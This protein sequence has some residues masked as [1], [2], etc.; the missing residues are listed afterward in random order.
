[1]PK[2]GSVLLYVHRNRKAHLD[3]KLRTA[4]STFTQLLNSESIMNY[5][6]LFILLQFVYYPVHA[7]LKT[8][9]ELSEISIFKASNCH[10]DL[11]D[12][13]VT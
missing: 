2:H 4:T 10:F 8:T 13:V 3:G 9:M 1:M 5:H 11:S 7:Y 6:L 12:M